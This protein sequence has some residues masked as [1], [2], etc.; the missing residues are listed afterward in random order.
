VKDPHETKALGGIGMA[1]GD[2]APGWGSG[3]DLCSIV[4]LGT[5]VALSASVYPSA[6]WRRQHPSPQ[7]VLSSE[8]VSETHPHCL[9]RAVP[10][11]PRC[12]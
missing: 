1:C 12:Q 11:N 8:P 9:F 7:V 6:Q 2:G 10:S 4:T 3:S 5:H